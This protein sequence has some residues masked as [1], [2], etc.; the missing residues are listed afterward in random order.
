MAIKLFLLLNKLKMYPHLLE[1]I[2][3]YFVDIEKVILNNQIISANTKSI[4]L[5]YNRYQNNNI[6]LLLI[7]L[8]FS[9]VEHLYLSF[10]K[11]SNID[12]LCKKLK[13]C[14]NLKSLYLSNNLIDDIRPFYFLESLKKLDSIDIAINNITDIYPF[15]NLIKKSNIKRINLFNNKLKN[16]NILINN[17]DFS[18]LEYLYIQSNNLNNESRNKIH[19]GVKNKSNKLIKIIVRIN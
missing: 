13:K 19:N 11:L 17:L 12:L 3:F 5:C 8:P 2:Y 18:N 15:I 7:S 9:H 16:P 4:Q 14:K 6:F 1:L 10:N